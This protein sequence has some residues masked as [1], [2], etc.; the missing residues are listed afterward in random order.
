MRLETER[1]IIASRTLDE[2]EAVRARETDPELQ[3]VYREIC[4]LMR[5]QPGRDEWACDWLIA[6]KD[7]TPVGGAGFKGAPDAQGD[8]EIGYEIFPAFRRQGYMS[9]ALRAMCAWALDMGASRV[10]AQTLP[11]NQ[12][13]QE[14][15]KKCGFVACGEGKEGPL[16]ELRPVCLT[17]EHHGNDTLLWAQEVPGACTRGASLEEALAKMPNELAACLAWRG[18]AYCPRPLRIAQEKQSDLDIRDADSDVLLAGEEKPLTREEYEALKA[19]CLRSA[20][21]FLTLY[22][23]IPDADASC[24]APRQTFYG[25]L[26]RTARQMYEHTL[27]VNDYYFG[28]IGVETDHEGDIVSCRARGFQ[29]LETAPDFLQNRLFS[30]SYGEE[31]TLRKVMRR[32]LWH[33]RIHARA[34]TR[35]AGRTFPESALPDP[36]CLTF[37]GRNSPP[38][39]EYE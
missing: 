11:E 5:S 15:L 19:L 6:R 10:L 24:L 17:W 18:E 9:E 12:A 39:G 29:A 35:M 36:F 31:W 14:L 16:F 32:F 25:P 23:S 1:L 26:P 33:D 4:A 30:G 22:R 21:D 2:M 28:E 20:R 7:G 3:Q 27:G 37:S 34:M 13:S 38:R 8:V